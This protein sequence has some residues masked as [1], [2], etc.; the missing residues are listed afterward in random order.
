MTACTDMLEVKPVSSVSGNTYY[1]TEQQVLN[2]VNGAYGH[3][4][5]LYNTADKTNFWAMTEMRSDNTTYQFNEADRGE[6]QTEELDEFLITTD[7][8]DVQRIWDIMYKGIQQSNIILNR[9]DGVSFENVALKAQYGAEARF[10]RALYY[11]HLVRLYGKVPLITKEVD[12]PDEAFTA[13]RASLDE[14]YAQI[15][16]DL[17]N[18]IHGLPDAY[19]I[20]NTG[21]AT[22]AA[23]LTM[24]G[25]VYLT[26]HYYE[27]AILML[28]QVT[29]LPYSLL[30][31]YAD[32]FDPDYKNHQESIFEVQFNAAVEGEASAFAYRFVPFN[33]GADIIGF[34][35][36]DR[37][38]AGYNIPTQDIVMTYEEGDERKKASVG[39]FVAEENGQ[40]DVAIGDSIPYI[41][42][43][44]H[45]F[46]ARGRTDENW[47][48]YRYAHVLLMLAEAHLEIGNTS[49][50]LDYVNQVRERASL[51]A[52]TEGIST[53]DLREAVYHEQRVELAFENHRWFDLLR[54]G[55]AM[56]VMNAHGE[57]QKTEQSRLSDAAYNILEYKMLYPIPQREI[58]LN[59]FEQNPGW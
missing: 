6:Q 37:S 2:A 23:A 47:P 38:F 12:V 21:R 20:Q 53:D 3:L 1:Q 26:L 14:V 24:L 22:R 42:K 54:T 10:M 25:E 16:N 7:N 19:D 58:R 49:E 11:F 33:S 27:Q 8:Y 41:K 45:S 30:P 29:Q 56:E 15:I 57:V 28:E 5:T 59:N 52:L 9:I 36:L 46:E 17:E 40:Y 32:A 44:V 51:N 13:E 43:F 50:T 55:R 4:Q 35:D 48:V 34:P 18:A 31:D 39:F